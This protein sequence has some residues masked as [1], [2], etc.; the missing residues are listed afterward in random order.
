MQTLKS[1]ARP[2]GVTQDLLGD[3]RGV[4]GPRPLTEPQPAGRKRLSGSGGD[5]F[6]AEG[7]TLQAEGVTLQ[8]EG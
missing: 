6:K 2:V 1:D 8:A 7:V 4:P 3:V 5:D